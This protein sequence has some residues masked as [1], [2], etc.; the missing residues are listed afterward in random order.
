MG[1]FGAKDTVSN[2]GV[3]WEKPILE[4]GGT[5]WGSI[6]VFC[7]HLCSYPLQP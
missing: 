7:T 3:P 6:V 5:P 4:A 1:P 2:S